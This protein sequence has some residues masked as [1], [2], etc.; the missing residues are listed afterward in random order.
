MQLSLYSPKPIHPFEE[1]PRVISSPVVTDSS[2][3]SPRSHP[4]AAVNPAHERPFYRLSPSVSLEQFLI[5][6]LTGLH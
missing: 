2:L 4:A 1:F 3:T 5:Q 6:K